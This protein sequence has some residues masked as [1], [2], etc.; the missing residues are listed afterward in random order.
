[1][2]QPRLDIMTFLLLAGTS[3]AGA[4]AISDVPVPVAAK[5][6]TDWVLDHLEAPEEIALGTIAVNVWARMLPRGLAAPLVSATLVLE[7]G[8]PPQRIPMRRVEEGAT[9]FVATLDTYAW[10]EDAAHSFSVVVTAED[11]EAKVGRGT[12]RAKPRI[13]ARDLLVLDANGFAHTWIGSGAGGFTPSGEVDAGLASACPWIGDVDG[14]GRPDALVPTRTGVLQVLHNRGNGTL[15]LSA[16]HRFGRAVEAA[17][18]DVD[19]D[20]KPDLVTVSADRS[21]EIRAPFDAEPI[22][23]SLTLAPERLALVDL[24][25]DGADEIAIGL[26]GFADSD[27]EIWSREDGAERRFGA[28]KR[29][30]PPGNARGRLVALRGI[31]GENGAPGRLVVAAELDGEGTLESWGGAADTESGMSFRAVRLPGEPIGVLPGRFSSA[32]DGLA[33]LV[34]VA[35]GRRVALIEVRETGEVLRRGTLEKAPE[36]LGAID[37]DGDGDDDLVTGGEDLRLW[38]NVRGDQFREAGE[39][40]YLTDAPI[41]AIASG[42]LDERQQPE[43][44]RNR[45]RATKE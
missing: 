41:V 38:I 8:D 12:I 16:S 40:P 35:D 7:D 43:P 14:D 5:A 11:G 9:Q 20:G 19:G 27:V 31:P 15:N 34:L 26:L 36:V 45:P 39:S 21:L 23:Q 4:Q 42:S 18:G 33:S 2:K 17:I 13:D 22:F 37:L 29:L 3:V 44:A 32:K 30:P 1:M 24:D 6:R 28:R 25:G 10:V